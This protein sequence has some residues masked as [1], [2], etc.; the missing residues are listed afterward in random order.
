MDLS[1]KTACVTCTPL[2]FSLAE[3]FARDFKKVYLHS[4]VSGSFVTMNAGLVGTGLPNV[5]KVAS[6]WDVVDD[7]DI[8][9]FPDLGH[10]ALQVYLEEHGHRVWGARHGDE[11]EV[12]REVCKQLMEEHGLP[13]APWDLV[14]GM[15]K[16]RAFLKAHERQWV[17]LDQWRGLTESWFS[18]SYDLSMPK[19]DELEKDLGGFKDQVEWIVEDDLPDKVEI[20]L[21]CYTVDGLYPSKTLTGIECK[22]SGYVSEFVEWQKIPEPLRRWFETMAPVIA[23][24]GYRGFLANE[25]RIGKDKVPF[26]IDACC[27]AGSPPSEL[28]QEFYTNISEIVWEGADGNLVD[29]KPIS[30]FGVQSVLKS[31]WAPGHWQPVSIAPEWERNLKLFN[32]VVVDG[33]RYVVPL[34]EDMSEVGSVVGWGDTLEAAVDMVTEAGESVQGY[35]LKFTMG[36]VEKVQEEMATLKELGVSP[37]SS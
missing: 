26:M 24:Y 1:T 32:E 3:R 14:K 19:L 34:D 11:L 21:D 36:P 27:R 13:V 2:F 4:P 35:D 29:P 22:D 18:E 30:K 7:V 17:K 9:I 23:E 12:F 33:Q 25:L 10:A 15:D 37:F 6:L 16:L 28:F 31:K 5:E 20:G 8:H